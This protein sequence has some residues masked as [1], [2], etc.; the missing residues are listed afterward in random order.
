M[1]GNFAVDLKCASF[2]S[3]C[4]DDLCTGH[5]VTTDLVRGKQDARD[6]AVKQSISPLKQNSDLTKQ[7]SILS[8]AATAPHINV[9]NNG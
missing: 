2:L 4:F 3:I 9:N 8:S 6:A 7:N 1:C 5:I